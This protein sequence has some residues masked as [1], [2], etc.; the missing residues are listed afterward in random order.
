MKFTIIESK[1]TGNQYAY[2]KKGIMYSMC[3]NVEMGQL[4]TSRYYRYE[5]VDM[6]RR[7]E[8]TVVG[9]ADLKLVIGSAVYL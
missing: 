7:G 1:T 8:A 6:L 2:P 4:S 3:Y 5:L 9:E